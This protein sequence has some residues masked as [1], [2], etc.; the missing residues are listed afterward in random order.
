MTT[1]LH[2]SYFN[3]IYNHL[4]ICNFNDQIF[5]KFYNLKNFIIF[6]SNT[7][8]YKSYIDELTIVLLRTGDDTVHP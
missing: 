4:L 7:I 1:V 5:C 2:F 3:M 8:Y 6:S